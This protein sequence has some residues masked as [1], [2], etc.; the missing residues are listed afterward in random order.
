MEVRR[1]PWIEWIYLRFASMIATI[2]MQGAGQ[3]TSSGLVR[4]LCTCFSDGSEGGKRHASGPGNN[5]GV[6]SPS[7]C[8]H[9]FGRPTCVIH[10]CS[11]R[12]V[13]LR[14][15]T[16]IRSADALYCLRRFNRIHIV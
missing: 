1:R 11:K 14:V 4:V 3:C 5:D 8:A 12:A 15:I 2:N 16:V 9:E 13:G 6:I 7:T 10:H